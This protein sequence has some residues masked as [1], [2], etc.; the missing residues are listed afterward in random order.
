MS[1]LSCSHSLEQAPC[2]AL[3]SHVSGSTTRA[4]THGMCASTAR[5]GARPRATAGVPASC[6]GDTAIAGAA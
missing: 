3:S 1:A 6:R 4:R 5:S 2:R